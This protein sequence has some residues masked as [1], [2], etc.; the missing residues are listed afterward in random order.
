MASPAL[1][2]GTNQYPLDAS[3][4]RLLLPEEPAYGWWNRT[5]NYV[6]RFMRHF[7]RRIK[8]GM[9]MRTAWHS[10]RVRMHDYR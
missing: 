5:V 6:P 4:A 7:R 2:Q 10:A 9:S 1:D 8:S 3:R